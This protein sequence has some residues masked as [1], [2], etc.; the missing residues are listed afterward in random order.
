[1]PKLI[2]LIGPAGSG[3]TTLACQL[4]TYRSYVRKPFAA[5]LKGML[6]NF[7]Q[8]Q[9]ADAVTIDRMLNGDLK[10]QPTEFLSNRSPRHA[11]QTLGTEWRETID[12]NLWVDAWERDVRKMWERSDWNVVVDDMRF[13]HEA[14]RVRSMNG[15]IVRITRPE[16]APNWTHSSEQGYLTIIPDYTILNKE[17]PS[18]MLRKFMA[19]IGED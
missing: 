9:G 17:T 15:V 19:Q 1:M 4:S 5:G 8:N 11:M 16:S 2:A 12:R 7:L 6:A 10:E 18:D 3:K 14:D 13:H